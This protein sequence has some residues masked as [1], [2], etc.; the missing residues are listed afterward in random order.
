M[1]AMVPRCPTVLVAEAQTVAELQAVVAF[2]GT[3]RGGIG[4][5]VMD[6]AA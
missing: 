3:W 4:N 2:G 5:Q 6:G 1:D